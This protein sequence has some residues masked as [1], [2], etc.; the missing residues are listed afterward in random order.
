M[1]QGRTNIIMTLQEQIRSWQSA[2][3][4]KDG[5]RA[6]LDYVLKNHNVEYCYYR[7]S[8]GFLWLGATYFIQ[9]LDKDQKELH[10]WR[11]D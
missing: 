6:A 1:V 4:I 2:D 10:W 11:M 8:C 9:V 7:W 5:Y 3:S